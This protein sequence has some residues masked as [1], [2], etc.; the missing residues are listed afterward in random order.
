MTIFTEICRFI[1]N[2]FL[3]YVK[4]L[5]LWYLQMEE[6]EFDR[7][8]NMAG[9][10]AQMNGQVVL[11]G[12][13]GELY[14]NDGFDHAM[15]DDGDF[16]ESFYE[17]DE[18]ESSGENETESEWETEDEWEVE[19]RSKSQDCPAVRRYF[20]DPN[21]LGWGRIRNLNPLS[22]WINNLLGR[23]IGK[24]GLYRRIR[25]NE[26]TFKNVSPKI[27]KPL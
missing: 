27:Q 15:E 10:Q 19:N 12:R 1:I 4:R 3:P 11:F 26:G 2:L 24:G 6:N 14:G 9:R 25:A 13:Q 16:D 17:V 7:Q 18:S 22:G 21:R 8:L 23:K 20:Q 5:F